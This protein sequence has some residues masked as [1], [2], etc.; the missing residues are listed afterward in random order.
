MGERR[1]PQPRRTI[2]QDVVEGVGAHLRCL[3][4]DLEVLYSFVLASEA[5]EGEGT[6]C[7]V[8]VLLLGRE[9]GL[10]TDVEGVET[11]HS[12]GM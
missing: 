1:L 10:I 12:L 8:N 6:K 4:E 9:V 3:Y 2:E 11:R 5:L 7:S